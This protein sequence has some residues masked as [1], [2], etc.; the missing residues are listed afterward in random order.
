MMSKRKTE[1]HVVL[2]GLLHSD[3]SYELVRGI[4]D[5]RQ[6]ATHWRIAGVGTEP[7]RSIKD[8]L[9]PEKVDGIIGSF[10]SPSSAESLLASGIPFVTVSAALPD[11]KLPRVASDFPAIGRMGG[12]YLLPRGFAQF[13]FVGLKGVWSSQQTLAGLREIV[14]EQGGRPCH[15]ID[16]TW[17][18]SPQSDAELQ[19]WLDALPKPIGIMAFVDHLGRNVINAAA[20]LGLRVPDDV[21]VLGMSN[22]RWATE[23]AE[24][25]MSSIEADHRLVGYQA[26]KLLDDMMAGK[27][28]PGPQWIAPKRVVSRRSTDVTIAE[29]AVVSQALQFIRDHC[30]QEIT[31]DDVLGN[32]D[33]S[34]RSLEKRMKKAVGHTPQIAITRARIERAR[35]LLLESDMKIGDISRAC[36]FRY[37]QGFV[38][39]FKRYIGITPGEYRRQHFTN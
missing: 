6:H 3:E 27:P 13:G 28:A 34:R 12:E 15:T 29:D 20:K 33:I 5:F 16:T 25:P 26:A 23:L 31:V 10:L 32:I 38:V 18:S 39:T 7:Y 30:T 9:D 17:L 1:C 14:E 11:M 21:A 19:Q 22:D 24:P 37:E 36:A 35:K 4:L 2:P 8:G